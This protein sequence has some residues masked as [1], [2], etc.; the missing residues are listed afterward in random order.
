MIELVISIR[1]SVQKSSADTGQKQ[2]NLTKGVVC[3]LA[4]LFSVGGGVYYYTLE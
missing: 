1:I 3:F 4:V 2:M